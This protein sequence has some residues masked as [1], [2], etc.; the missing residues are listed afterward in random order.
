MASSPRLDVRASRLIPLYATDPTPGNDTAQVPWSELAHTVPKRELADLLDAPEL[1]ALGASDVATLVALWA[2]TNREGIAWPGVDAI[3]RRAH[4]CRRTCVTALERLGRVGLVVR[5]VPELRARRRRET[6]TYQLPT[7]R[8]P[9]SAPPVASAPNP[10][11]SAERTPSCALVGSLD[12]PPVAL[13]SLSASLIPVIP[14][15]A[16]GAPDAPRP[17]EPELRW[18][19]AWVQLALPAAPGA[20][21]APRAPAPTSAPGATAGGHQVQTLPS[22]ETR[23]KEPENAGAGAQ[24][25]RAQRAAHNRET[26]AA[27]AREKRTP[28]PRPVAALTARAPVVPDL[29]ERTAALAELRAWRTAHPILPGLGPTQAVPVAPS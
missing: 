25:T 6:S 14:P 15:G 19:E 10:E 26:W 2:F 21:V 5:Q 12:A 20:A 8:R 24:A 1:R 23:E 4:V 7:P 9:A 17:D 16:T 11:R 29:A 18:G 27:R 3:A 22:K 28:V 13:S